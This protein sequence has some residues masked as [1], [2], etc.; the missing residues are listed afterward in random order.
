[1]TNI[2]SAGHSWGA[3]TP[4]GK[5]RPTKLTPKVAETIFRALR[6]WHHFE[7]ACAMAG[8]GKTSAYAWL[9][10]GADLAERVESG[11]VRMSSLRAEDRRKVDFSNGVRASVAA[12]EGQGI[13]WIARAAGLPHRET[14]TKETIVGTDADGEPIYG[15]EVTTIEKPASL[16]AATW[17]MEHRFPDRWATRHELSGPGGRAVPV[18]TTH[19]IGADAKAL[20]FGKLDA[21]AANLAEPLP[22]AIDV[23]STEADLPDVEEA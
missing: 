22:D 17:L 19:E 14:R 6:T 16:N 7:T 5:G 9:R 8:V 23:A 12:A 1:M 18:E 3:K 11:E 15:T 2:T 13:D 4:R 21:M 10:D 20:L